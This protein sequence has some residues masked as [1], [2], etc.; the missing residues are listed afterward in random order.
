MFVTKYFVDLIYELQEESIK[1]VICLQI[2]TGYNLEDDRCEC[3][4]LQDYKENEQVRDIFSIFLYAVEFSW[5]FLVT[6]KQQM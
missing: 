4:A 1:A 6:Y 5:V 2:T 3:V